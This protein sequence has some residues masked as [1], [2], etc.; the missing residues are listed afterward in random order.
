MFHRSIGVLATAALV[1]SFATATATTANAGQPSINGTGVTA[2]AAQPSAQL[3]SL[4]K[5]ST[6]QADAGYRQLV[7][8]LKSAGAT[9]SNGLVSYNLPGY[10]EIVLSEPATGS[11]ALSSGGAHVLIGG[12]WDGWQGPY[13]SFNRVD[14]G[15]LLAGGS[16]AVAAAICFIPAVGQA[17]CVAA[18]AIV[19]IAFYYLTEYGRC[20]TSK[21]NLREYVWSNKTGCYK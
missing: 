19:A 13:V 3:G 7:A 16:A 4:A 17:A 14:Q 12:G 21:P 15:A 10:G 2:E 9:S 5:L 18:V 8:A 20:P 6:S 1:L 11:P